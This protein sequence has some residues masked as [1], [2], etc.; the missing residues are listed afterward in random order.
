MVLLIR[1]FTVANEMDCG[2]MSVVAVAF[3]ASSLAV[4]YAHGTGDPVEDGG[5]SPA[6]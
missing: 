6:I 4:W 3:F 2:V 1:A 5:A